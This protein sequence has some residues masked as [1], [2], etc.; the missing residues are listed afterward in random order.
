MFECK[1]IRIFLMQNKMSNSLLMI[2]THTHTH[3]HTLDYVCMAD[4]DESGD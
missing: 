3:T 1:C 2:Y 4:G